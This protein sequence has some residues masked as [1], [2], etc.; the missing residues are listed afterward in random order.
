KEHRQRLERDAERDDEVQDVPTAIRGVR[1]DP[2]RHAEKSRDVH[3]DEGQ[4]EADDEQP[5]VPAS[6]TLAQHPAGYLGEPVVERREDREHQSAEQHEL[7]L[8]A[9]DIATLT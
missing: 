1:V 7:E 2:P 3:R 5:E 4:V 8:P 6:E 9:T